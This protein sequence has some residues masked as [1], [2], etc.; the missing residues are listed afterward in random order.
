MGIKLQ[1]SEV[2][3]L[4]RDIRKKFEA[5]R[6]LSQYSSEFKLKKGAII[7]SMIKDAKEIISESKYFPQIKRIILF[8]SAV[9][10]KLTFSSDIDVAVEFD[11][12]TKR[13]ATIF[14]IAILS[15]LPDKM[16]VQVFNVLPDK[17]KDDIQKKGK[18]LY[19]KKN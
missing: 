8:G 5:V 15:K 10:N 14:R 9:E 11:E 17:L 7:K 18:V 12:I 2:I 4:S 13:E 19:E 6:E 16:D 3:R 1:P